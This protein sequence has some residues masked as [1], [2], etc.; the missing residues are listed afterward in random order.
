VA[1]HIHYWLID[2]NNFGVCKYCGAKRQFP[3]W[4]PHFDQR[5]RTTIEGFE[6]D[7]IP[8]GYHLQE[9]K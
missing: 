3:R 4:K 1:K 7:Y 8:S 9:V 5:E 6:S 2:G